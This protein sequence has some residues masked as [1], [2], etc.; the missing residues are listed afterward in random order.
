MD[1]T[2]SAHAIQRHAADAEHVRCFVNRDLQRQAAD[3]CCFRNG[4]DV[5][6]ACL[7]VIVHEIRLHDAVTTCY[8]ITHNFI[9]VY[10]V[11]NFVKG[12]VIFL[13]EA[14]IFSRLRRDRSLSSSVPHRRNISPVT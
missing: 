6:L 13:V 12:V 14:T 11:D 8:S 5:T 9:F 4:A 2:R 1:L 7:S 3:N 10:V